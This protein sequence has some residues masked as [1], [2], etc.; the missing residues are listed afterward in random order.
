MINRALTRLKAVQIIYS[1]YQ[2][3]GTTKEQCI[4]MLDKSQDE[5]Y[6]L[7]RHMLALLT[8]IRYYA[9]RRADSIEAR[10]QRLRTK[11]GELPPDALLGQNKFL[12]ML[13]SN[14]ELQKFRENRVALWEVGDTFLKRMVDLFVQSELF[15]DYVATGDRSYEA[16]RELVRKLYKYY[17]QENDDLDQLLEEKSLLWNDD[18]EIVDSF[19][20]K[21]IKRMDER[22]TPDMA[23]LPQFD[24]G[25]DMTFGHKLLT[26][27]I[28]REEELRKLVSSHVRGWDFNRVALM[29][30][31]IM[32]LALAEILAFSEIPLNVTFNEYINIAKCYSTPKSGAYINGLLDTVVKQLRQEG[33]ILK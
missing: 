24:E 17:M 6:D 14:K 25:E 7:Y 1:Y 13:D 16:D 4:K 31:L 9:E 23:L 30:V 22:S 32:Q 12:L 3:E 21:T 8:D 20:L 29:D 28:E 18:K 15:S 11:L 10:A 27:A 5:A 19:V 2:N 26:T 33:A